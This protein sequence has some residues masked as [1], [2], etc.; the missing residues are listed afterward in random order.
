MVTQDPVRSTIQN[1]VVNFGQTLELHVSPETFLTRLS[2]ADLVVIDISSPEGRICLPQVSL[3]N[4]HRPVI[5]LASSDQRAAALESQRL[6]AFAVLPSPATEDELTYHIGHALTTLAERFD[7][8]KLG[9][10]HRMISLGNDFALITPVALSLVET[11]LPP[12][13]SRKTSV[14]LGLV[15]VITNAIEHGNLGISYEQKR[16]ALRGSVFYNLASER[17][18]MS[19]W[20][21]R[22]V[23]IKSCVDP[24][25]SVISYEVEDQG[26]GFDW[27]NLPDPT[28]PNNINARHG[29][30]ILMASHAF[31]AMRYNELGNS[32]ILE[33]P[34]DDGA[35]EEE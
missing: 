25:R 6:G 30:G 5:V 34:L 7:P 22:V 31:A 1:V 24:T 33:L 15:E 14:A 8:R 4:N 3:S 23:R 29:R 26:D 28:D 32:V 10:Q 18:A 21:D 17:A 27:R 9:L 12:G 2:E 20:K 19:P 35:T 16:E 11:T 13:D